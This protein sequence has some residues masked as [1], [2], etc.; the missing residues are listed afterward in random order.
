MQ[1][2]AATTFQPSLQPPFHLS[3]VS[4]KENAS[5]LV[6]VLKEG[7]VL[8]WEELRLCHQRTMG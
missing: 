2:S 3:A 4:G 5:W 1:F 8:L 6:C 7:K